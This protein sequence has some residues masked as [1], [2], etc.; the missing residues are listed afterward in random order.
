[1]REEDLV[2]LRADRVLQLEPSR[3]FLLLDDLVVR[4]VDRD[5]LAPR[6]AVARIV[7]RIV[8]V[9]VRV[10]SRRLLLV[11]IGDRKASLQLGKHR[12]VTLEALAPLEVLDENV[13]LERGL[14]AEELVL[15]GL[16]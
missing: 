8:G 13:G 15:V 7:D 6:V 5:R 16:D 4:E 2:E 10:G 9:E 3:A 12:R 1:D 11:L 14:D